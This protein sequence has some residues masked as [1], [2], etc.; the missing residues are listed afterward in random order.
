MGDYRRSI[1]I[2]GT[3]L[4]VAV[5][6]VLR[7][8]EEKLPLEPI[9]R[10]FQ[11]LY[12]TAGPAI[13]RI[14]RVKDG[15]PVGSGVIV[16]A[17]GHVVTGAGCA[18]ETGQ[19]DSLVFYLA[20]GGRATGTALGW[21]NEWGIGL[22]KITEKG[23]WPYVQLGE[24][25]HVRAGQLCAEYRYSRSAG[26]QFEH[27]PTLRL[28]CVNRSAAP[29]WL[30]TS[31]RSEHSS[32]DLEGGLLDLDGRLVGVTT[33]RYGGQDPICTS[34][35]VIRQHWD[36]LVSGKDVD[37]LRLLS[38]EESSR[39]SPG[40]IGPKHRLTEAKES[41]SPAIEKAKLATI[42]IR[43]TGEQIGF[44]AVVVTADGYVTTCAHAFWPLPG[45]AVTIS[46]PDGRDTA[47]KVLGADWVS[48]I[49]LVKIT[50]KGPWPHAE[51]GNSTIMGPNEPCVVMGYPVSHKDRQPLV[52]R[53]HIVNQQGD[54]YLSPSPSGETYGGDSGG[55]VFDLEGRLVAVIQGQSFSGIGQHGRVE[56]FREHWDFLAAGKPVD[57]MSTEPYG[58][59]TEAFG[60]LAN[61]LPPVLVEVL[62]D[63][64]PRALGTIVR[65]DGRILTKAS[66]LYGALSCRFGDGRILPATIDSVS[67]QHDLAVLKVDAQN[68]PTAEFCPSEKTPVGTLIAALIPSKPAVAGMVCTPVRSIARE[69]GVA[70]VG[71]R[72]SDRGLEV[73][74]DEWAR[75]FDI[76]LRK[77][78]IIVQVE[79]HRKPDP[80]TFERAVERAEDKCAGDPIRVSVKRGDETLEF[81]FPLAPVW[82]PYPKY[83]SRRCSG[84]PS[85]CDADIPLTP[86]TCGGPVIDRTGRV[87][88]IAIACRDHGRIHVIPAVVARA[89]VNELRQTA[90]N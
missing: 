23:P 59:I 68:L 79:D 45:D 89:V 4:I 26:N 63:E 14:A 29:V 55:G 9:E 76:P 12:E 6:P 28:R 53:A 78:D 83:I 84:F 18:R 16:T 25:T 74:E 17:D 75:S 43:R 27:E 5:P 56:L 13:V 7:A 33:A 62:S 50:E 48:D 85:A 90:P 37:R 21:S 2:V 54:Y 31:S 52:R 81:H 49:S 15:T 51:L 77:G 61:D 19:G 72:D 30:T 88:G 60:R 71:V 65:S 11:V 22:V 47:G 42:R 20:G 58:Q 34:V 87:A 67:P 66:E 44:S 64:K 40:T 41:V 10:R 8:S 3:L 57:V 36:A 70:G 24:A 35:D 1:L 73:Y 32:F 82:S 38:S 69:R 39:E 46:L 80:E 86:E